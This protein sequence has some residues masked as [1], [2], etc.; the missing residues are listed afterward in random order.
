MIP[1]SGC[2]Q[3]PPDQPG[4]CRQSWAPHHARYTT[5][6]GTID[7]TVIGALEQPPRAMLGYQHNRRKTHATTPTLS[8]LK[9]VQSSANAG[10]GEQ[11][12]E[13][14]VVSIRQHKLQRTRFSNGS[15]PKGDRTDCSTAANSVLCDVR[16]GIGNDADDRCA[17]IEVK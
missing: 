17:V 5:P 16:L 1:S 3:W 14:R 7:A 12:L 8:R 2:L 10:E 4:S 13:I 6:R 9:I 11:G 15:R